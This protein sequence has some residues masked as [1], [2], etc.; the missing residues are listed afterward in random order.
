MRGL[1]F[2]FALPPNHAFFSHS[3]PLVYQRGAT[4]FE[5]IYQK[6]LLD[7]DINEKK[8]DILVL[9]TDIDMIPEI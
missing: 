1:V 5:E 8:T 4:N 6:L 3:Y 7:G 2:Q 9:E